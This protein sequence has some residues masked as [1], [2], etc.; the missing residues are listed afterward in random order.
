MSAKGDIY[1]SLNHFVGSEKMRAH[2]HGGM[3]VVINF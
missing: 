2:V 3:R 1:R